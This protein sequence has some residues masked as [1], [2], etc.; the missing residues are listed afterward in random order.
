LTA[1]VG[2]IPS[3]LLLKAPPVIRTLLG[4]PKSMPAML[5]EADDQTALAQARGDVRT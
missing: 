3:N 2:G 1:E 4:L 5:R